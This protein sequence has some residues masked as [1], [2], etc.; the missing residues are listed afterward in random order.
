MIQ[1]NKNLCGKRV[2]VGHGRLLT[3]LPKIG[4][5]INESTIDKIN[6]AVNIRDGNEKTTMH[7]DIKYHNVHLDVLTSLNCA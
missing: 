1:T 7:A 2:V 5:L 6:V 3:H 4:T